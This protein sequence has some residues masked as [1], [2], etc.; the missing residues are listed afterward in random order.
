MLGNHTLFEKKSPTKSS[1]LSGKS[2][3]L[4][5]SESAYENE[6]NRTRN[7]LKALAMGNQ[8]KS[9]LI[10]NSET[11][12]S[13]NPLEGSGKVSLTVIKQPKKKMQFLTKERR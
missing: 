2:H 13:T 8:G 9:N 5:S 1:I 3:S 10:I 12:F 11:Q 4:S 6:K 7:N